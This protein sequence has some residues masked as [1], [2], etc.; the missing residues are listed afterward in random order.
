MPDVRVFQDSSNRLKNQVYTDNGSTLISLKSDG[1]GKL[2]VTN[3]AGSPL[4]VQSTDLD[5]RNLNTTDD[6]IKV[7][8]TDGTTNRQLKTDTGGNLNVVSND[9]DIRPLT[10]AEDSIKISGNDGTTNRVL[11][12]DASGNLYAI[13]MPQFTSVNLG[14]IS[15]ALTASATL[16][17][18]I[19]R[20]SAYGFFVKNTGLGVVLLGIELSPDNVNWYTNLSGVNLPLNGATYITSTYF[21]QYIRMTYVAVAL[22][23]STLITYFQA[24]S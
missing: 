3:A 8:G 5:I 6:S 13:T 22:T 10:A 15:V 24:Q 1:D 12:T 17:Q 14:P 16:A 18:D 2:I 19:S 4:T 21:L 7:Y 20:Q 9:L 23:P 11:R